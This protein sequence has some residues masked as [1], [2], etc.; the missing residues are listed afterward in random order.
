[1]AVEKAR[2]STVLGLHLRALLQQDTTSAMKMERPEPEGPKTKLEL[3]GTGENP[4]DTRLE[5]AAR[6]RTGAPQNI[7]RETEEGPVSPRW[8]SQWTEFVKIVHSHPSGERTPQLPETRPTDLMHNFP[9]PFEGA[10]ATSRWPNEAKEGRPIPGLNRMPPRLSCKPDFA[11]QRDTEGIKVI[12]IEEPGGPEIHRQRFRQFR[13]QEAGGPWESYCRLRELCHQWLMPESHTKEQILEM[14]ILEQFL[15]ILPQEM[16]SWVRERGSESC[17]QAVALAENFLLRKQ[18]AERQD[19]QGS[20]AKQEAVPRFPVSDG[21]SLETALGQLYREVKL[22]QD[23]ETTALGAWKPTE[24]VGMPSER[25]KCQDLEDLLKRTEPKKFQGNEMVEHRSNSLISQAGSLY[26]MAIQQA[27][28]KENKKSK[29]LGENLFRDKSH[30]NR[31]PR[32][33]SGEKLYECSDCGK[34]FVSKSG[35]VVH[36]RIH[37]GEKPYECSHCGKSFR[38]SSQLNS[39]SRIHT[40]EK[41]F[42]CLDC[43]KGFGRSSNLISHQRIHTGEKPYACSVCNKRFCDKSS[44]VRHERLHTGDNP[45]KCTVCGKSFSQSHHLITHQRSHTGEKPYRC[46]HCSKS[47]CDKSTYIRHQKNHTGEKPYKCPDCGECFSRSKHFIRHQNIHSARELYPCL[48]CGESFCRKSSLKTHQRIHTGEKPFECTDCGK[49]FNRS[50]NLIS[51]QRIHTG[52]KPYA[53]PECGKRFN[54]RAH[55]MGHQRVHMQNRENP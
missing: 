5:M 28:H 14:V 30:L 37:S 43:G 24:N 49:K 21:T 7:K 2:G 13:Y 50:T 27:L 41:P 18:E 55:L 39:H 9:A 51:H 3:G 19:Q 1:M 26:E 36:S 29:K 8:E 11:D 52:E 45:Y 38:Q 22:E 48:D 46:L 23:G 12:K 17:I 34:A 54:R 33:Q 20:E 53:C 10:A 6:G 44:L 32:T 47:F 40:G 35:Y 4:E 16:L 25:G 31:H 15:S 42:K